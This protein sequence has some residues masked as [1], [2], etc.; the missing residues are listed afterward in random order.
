MCRYASGRSIEVTY[1]SF[2][3]DACMDSGVSIFN[4]GKARNLLRQLKSITGLEQ[5]PSFGTKNKRLSV[6]LPFQLRLSVASLE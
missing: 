1:S 5:L 6:F 2:L 4:F 3:R